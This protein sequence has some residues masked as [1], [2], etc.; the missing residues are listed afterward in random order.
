MKKIIYFLLIVLFSSNLSVAASF[1]Q[2]IDWSL[3][4]DTTTSTTG[5]MITESNQDSEANAIFMEVF[6]GLIE[7]SPGVFDWDDLDDTINNTNKKIL[8]RLEVNSKCFAPSWS[9]IPALENKSLEFWK[10]EYLAQITAFIHAFADKYAHNPKI[11]GVH[12]GIADGEFYNKDSNG[13]Y[14]LDAGGN[15]TNIA[16][17]TPMYAYGNYRDGWGEFWMNENLGESSASYA[18][19]LTASNFKSSVIDIIDMYVNAFGEHKN[20][21]AFMSYTKVFDS[22]TESIRGQA[23]NA[24]LSSI[25]QHAKNE[26][27]GNREGEIE[28]WMRYTGNYY[29]VNLNTSKDGNCSLVF[30]ETFADSIIDNGLYWGD[31]NEFYGNWVSD[32]GNVENQPYRFYVSS[33]RAL[34]MRR[35]YVS[36]SSLD[37]LRAF[38]SEF[39][40]AS[41]ITYLSKTLGRT[42]T[43]TPDAFVLLGDRTLNMSAGLYPEEYIVDSDTTEQCLINSESRGYVVVSEFGRWLSLVSQTQPDENMRKNMPT[44]DNNWGAGHLISDRG[45]GQFYELYARKSNEMLF[46]IN[47]QLMQERCPNGCNTEVKISFKDYSAVDLRVEYADGSSQIIRTSGDGNIK[48]VTFPISSVFMNTHR[49]ADFSIKTMDGSQLSVLI[50]RLN[51]ISEIVNYVAPDTPIAISPIGN[52]STQVTF[53]WQATPGATH[54]NVS[55]ENYTTGKWVESYYHPGSFFGCTN[56][57]GVCRYTVNNLSKGNN[58]W[59]VKAKNANGESEWSSGL[60]FTPTSDFSFANILPAILY[61]LH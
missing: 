59:W 21:L 12:V 58:E 16:C 17:P 31:E 42:R 1:S 2:G 53:E 27:L 50:V 49:G 40:T 6:W 5:G 18:A 24:Q 4:S 48:T 26:G 38:S 29:G 33:L 30:D 46:D 3:P 57:I 56:N 36:V 43:D 37:Y 20:K 55:Y 7:T 52:T 13:E 19:G 34:Q 54:Y 8:I 51:I 61:L 14:I 39:N 47:D 11:I 22:D 28:D 35:N 45:I 25:I 44:D 23:I 41:F 60:E 10:P 9:T 32:L 15:P